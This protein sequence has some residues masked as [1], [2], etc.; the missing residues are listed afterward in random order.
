MIDGIVLKITISDLFDVAFD[1]L[2]GIG[3]ILGESIG[4]ILCLVIVSIL[5]ITI[6]TD[7]YSRIQEDR[8]LSYVISFFVI[9][10]NIAMMVLGILHKDR[11]WTWSLLLWIGEI[12]TIILCIYS[13]YLVFNFSYVYQR[14]SRYI[15]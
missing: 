4:F 15:W 9:G 7:L 12:I 3:R 5:I 11:N 8:L 13:G 1:L 2:R 10:G 14:S 6:T